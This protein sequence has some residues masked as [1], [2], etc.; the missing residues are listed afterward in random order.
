MRWLAIVLLLLGLSACKKHFG[1]ASDPP[2]EQAC[3]KLL[4]DCAAECKGGAKAEKDGSAPACYET[5][6]RA[7]GA[8]RTCAQ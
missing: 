2:D 5:C 1:F 7:Y 4:D 8:C 6:G 3:E